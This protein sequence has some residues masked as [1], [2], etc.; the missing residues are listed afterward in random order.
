MDVTSDDTGLTF[1]RARTAEE[2]RR[3]EHEAAVL[4]QAA[5][6]GIVQLL[7]TEG[8]DP[9]EALVLRTVSGGDLTAMAAQPTPVIAGLGAA[10]A[11]TVADLHALGFS[12]GGIEASHVL[13]D[14]AGRPVLCSLGRSKATVTATGADRLHE[15][16]LRALAAMLLQLLPR[17]GPSRVARTLRSLATPGRR[18]PRRDAS[19]LARHLT[20]A[21]PDARLPGS[22]TAGAPAASGA[23]CRSGRL[24]GPIR[25]IMAVPPGKLVG[26]GVGCCVLIAGAAVLADREAASGRPAAGAAGPAAAP[27]PAADD[28]CVPIPGSAG[29]LI[30]P[31]GRY[32]LGQPGDVIVMGRWRCS[33]TALPAVLRPRTGDVWTFDSWPAPDHPLVG[34]LVAHVTSASSLRVRPGPSGCDELEIDRPD[35]PPVTIAGVAL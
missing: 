11:T 3:I 13:L 27:C 14:E 6:P 2:R 34:R 16:D 24:S 1:K 10:V 33:P 18:H 19:W 4:R 15:D 25:R 31:A 32:Q 20:A 21:V 30:G 12:H 26:A 17:D 5:H 35:L 29:G 7:A 23:H 9:T 8:G 22:G 28:G